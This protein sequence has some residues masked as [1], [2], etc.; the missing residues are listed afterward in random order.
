VSQQ[1]TSTI[2]LTEPMLAD[3]FATATAPLE[4]RGREMLNE[5]LHGT[6]DEVPGPPDA[7]GRLVTA[8]QW[9][10]G[11]VRGLVDGDRVEVAVARSGGARARFGGPV[12][13]GRLEPRPDGAVLVGR[14]QQQPG[15]WTGLLMM[16][17]LPLGAG[18]L[19][20]FGVAPWQSRSDSPMWTAVA[21][22]CVFAPVAVCAS[23]VVLGR[24]RD[25][26]PILRNWLRAVLGR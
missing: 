1:N 23:A 25:D 11:Q 19:G 14:Y 4:K 12:F 3:V 8:L 5:L 2:R 24:W 26:V 7:A 13:Y 21:M 9:S 16:W 22:P 18:L 20:V 17:A 10:A 6:P 15:T